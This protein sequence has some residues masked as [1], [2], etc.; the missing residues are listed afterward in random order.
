[1]TISAYN[2]HFF[3]RKSGFHR[4]ENVVPGAVLLYRGYKR[5]SQQ[6]ELKYEYGQGGSN[7]YSTA[8][9][10]HISNSGSS[11]ALR[12]AIISGNLP[13]LPS[14]GMKQVDYIYR[15]VA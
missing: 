2:D 8:L 3:C 5:E 7:W 6:T 11:H 4:I 12:Y 1:M 15:L 9:R 13:L 14:P 10:S